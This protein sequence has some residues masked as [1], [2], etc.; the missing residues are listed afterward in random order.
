MHENAVVRFS[1]HT[2]RMNN[3][4]FDFR[5]LRLF[6]FTIIRLLFRNILVFSRIFAGLLLTVVHLL[7][8]FCRCMLML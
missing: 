2:L 7:V 3:I 4:L 1:V 6:D 8:N 5:V